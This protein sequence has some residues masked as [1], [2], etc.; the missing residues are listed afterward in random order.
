LQPGAPEGRPDVGL[1]GLQSEIAEA[2]SF[3]PAQRDARDVTVLELVSVHHRQGVGTARVAAAVVAVI[4]IVVDDDHRVVVPAQRSPAAIVMTPVPMHPG[5]TPGIVGDPVPAETQ[6]PVPAAVVV[7]APA[8]RLVGDPG[9]A[10]NRIPDPA[11]VVIGS[12]IIHI[13]AGNPDITIRPFI[14][15]AAVLGKLVFIVIKLRGKI[16]LGNILAV[17]GVPVGVP[18][19]EIIP[20]V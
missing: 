4:E 6:P 14:G 10:A 5:G 17:E 13:D 7:G 18:V 8:P 16:A 11:A 19:I 15:P 9:P 2:G 12:P 3:D 20:A 1:P